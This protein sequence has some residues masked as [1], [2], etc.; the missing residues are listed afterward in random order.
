MVHRLVYQARFGFTSQTFCN[1]LLKLGWHGHVRLP[2]QWTVT[3]NQL[4]LDWSLANK[5]H[6]I[7]QPKV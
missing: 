5:P 3:P 6:A 2:I 4:A 7:N 1:T